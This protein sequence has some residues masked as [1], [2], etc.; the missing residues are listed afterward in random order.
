MAQANM[1][2]RKKMP[3]SAVTPAPARERAAIRLQD[4]RVKAACRVSRPSGD[5]QEI[6]EDGLATFEALRGVRERANGTI[7]RIIR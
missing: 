4:L 3:S 7:D 5:L 6:R 2:K 1:R